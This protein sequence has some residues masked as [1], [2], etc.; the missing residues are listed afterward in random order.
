[1]LEDDELEL[2]DVVWVDPVFCGLADKVLLFASSCRVAL[3]GIST[4]AHRVIKL[5]ELDNEGVVVVLEEGL[6]S[7]AGGEDGLE[8]PARGFLVPVSANW[9]EEAWLDTRHA[10]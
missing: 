4:G 9:V 5:G 10:S 8:H 1:M 2:G 7:Q 3:D 6:P